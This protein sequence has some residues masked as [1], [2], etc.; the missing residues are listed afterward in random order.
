MSKKIGQTIHALEHTKL[1][2][3]IDAVF[4]YTCNPPSKDVLSQ[5]EIKTIGDDFGCRDA[6]EVLLI[7]ITVYEKLGYVVRDSDLP[8]VSEQL[9]RSLHNYIVKKS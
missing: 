3:S 4:H 7:P 6:R 5:L 2:K 1:I 8:I 9:L